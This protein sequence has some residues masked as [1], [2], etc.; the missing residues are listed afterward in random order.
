M[1]QG[2]QN[3]WFHQLRVCPRIWFKE[4]AVTNSPGDDCA[5]SA[6][7]TVLRADTDE[8]APSS[9]PSSCSSDEHDIPPAP[10][11]YVL[12]RVR[13]PRPAQPYLRQTT[14][15]KF[16]STIKVHRFFRIRKMDIRRHFTVIRKA[17]WTQDIEE[18]VPDSEAED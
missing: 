17:K 6:D 7:E 2:F 8:M 10:V 11:Y 9:T 3:A 5:G 12:R 18:I 16:F 4:E 1:L 14:L 15:Q 13:P